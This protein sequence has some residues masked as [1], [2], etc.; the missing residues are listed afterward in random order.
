MSNENKH[1]AEVEQ[2]EVDVEAFGKRNEKPPKAKKYRVRIDDKQHVID[3]QFVTGAEL[4]QVAGK[5]PMDR[6]RIH[7]KLHGGQML[8]IGYTQQVD[9]GTPGLERFTTYER[10]VTDGEVAAPPL[11]RAFR[12]PEDDE[13]YLD[14]LGLAWETITE[15]NVR[16]LIIRDHPLPAGYQAD[17]A[18]VAIRI[19]GGYPPSKLDMV[20][21]CPAL[22]H[23]DGK[24]IRT[25]STLLL[26]SRSFQQWSRHYTWREEIDSLAT[27][28]CRV[29]DWLLAE[30]TRG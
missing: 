6:F 23:L 3:H 28:H 30:L 9:L 26:D 5:V 22:G 27:H 21:F 11:R 12:L 7:Q 8:E 2:E 18:D 16:W 29:K 19:T 20:Y 10:T 4:L 17:Q 1:E 15:S 14:S 25:V 24:P 13:D